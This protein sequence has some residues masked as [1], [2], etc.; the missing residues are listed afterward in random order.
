MM[1]MILKI[2]KM[3]KEIKYKLNCIICNK[4]IEESEYTNAV[5]C[6]SECFHINHWNEMI[7]NKDSPKIARINREQ[8]YI[9][10]EDKN[11]L[12]RG[13][14]GRKFKIKFF[15][16]REIISTNLWYN[17]EIPESHRELLPDNAE[18]I[19]EEMEEVVLF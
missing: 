1:F 18:F 3:R 14:S 16:G 6:S 7:K 2:L 19:I 12:F 15:D 5:L 11:I 8:Y 17:G 10:D 9:E 13:Y 4:E